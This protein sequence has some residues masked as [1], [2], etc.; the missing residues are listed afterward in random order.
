M[1]PQAVWELR[2]TK[3]GMEQAR[4]HNI[5]NSVNPIMSEVSRTLK[6]QSQ[7][8]KA[9]IGASMLPYIEQGYSLRGL[10]A[11]MNKAGWTT[12]KVTYA[13]GTTVGGQP[14]SSSY[15]HK[16]LVAC[17]DLEE[18]WQQKVQERAEEHERRLQE[19]EDRKTALKAAQNAARAQGAAPRRNPV[20]PGHCARGLVKKRAAKRARGEE[21][22][23]V[24]LSDSG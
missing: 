14:L 23:V 9:R 22:S 15:V 20:L 3:A 11:A 8:W 17:P 13:K 21:G 19:N 7:D 12:F 1:G 5:G 16:V 10:A 4:I 24:A 18:L 6:A 2:G